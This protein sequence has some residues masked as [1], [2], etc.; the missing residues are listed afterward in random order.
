MMKF[1]R[2]GRNFVDFL[3]FLSY[4]PL[5]VEIHERI[6]TKPLENLSDPFTDENLNVDSYKNPKTETPS[7]NVRIQKK[8]ELNN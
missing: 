1:D 3:D 5:F 2:E 6:I 8:I 7:T 4:L